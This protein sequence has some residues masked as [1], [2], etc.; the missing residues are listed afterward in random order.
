MRMQRQRHVTGGFLGGAGTGDM[1]RGTI[2]NIFQGNV[3]RPLEATEINGWRE[4]D[5]PQSKPWKKCIWS[6]FLGSLTVKDMKSSFT[7]TWDPRTLG[8]VYLCQH[9]S[10]VIHWPAASETWM[11]ETKI[12]TP[13]H[14]WKWSKTLAEVDWPARGVLLDLSD[15]SIPVEWSRSPHTSRKE[16]V[17]LYIYIYVCICISIYIYIFKKIRQ[18]KYER[19]HRLSSDK[20]KREIIRDS[21]IGPIDIPM[22]PP[23]QQPAPGFA[24]FPLGNCGKQMELLSFSRNPLGFIILFHN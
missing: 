24:S 12:H 7:P 21:K 4:V 13:H 9:Y 11:K 20:K 5:G 14:K 8:M 16:N 19:V 22:T 18:W 17:S 10:S 1:T 15:L 6:W 23:E 2:S 3:Q